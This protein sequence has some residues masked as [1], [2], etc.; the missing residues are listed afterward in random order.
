MNVS[1]P[2][3]DVQ[4]L[5]Q[6]M[7]N[8]LSDDQLAY[9]SIIDNIT[10]SLSKALMVAEQPGGL[11][12]D[13]FLAAI[14]EA[15]QSAMQSLTE[16]TFPLTLS[17]QH[18]ILGIVQDSLKLIVQPDMSFAS[19]RNISLLILMRAESIIQQTIPERFAEYPLSG[20]KVATTYLE[21]IAT[22][23]GPDNWNQIILTEMMTIQ[24]LLPANSTAHTYVSALINVTNFILESGQG[25]SLWA[26]FQNASVQNVN[27]IIGQMGK[28][29]S[30]LW[31]L[32]MGRPGSHTTAPPLEAFAHFAP[33]LEQVMTN[34]ADQDTWHKL[35]KMLEALLSTLKGTEL[36]ENV[37][38]V[39]P[40]FEKIVES[41][42]KN[43]QAEN[44]LIQSLQMPVVT[45]MK[46]IAQSVNTSHFN[47]SE[48]LG[49]SEWQHAIERLLQAAEQVR[50]GSLLCTLC[51]TVF[52][53]LHSHLLT[54]FL[55]TRLRV[56]VC[57]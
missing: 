15:V 47:L 51:I 24:R 10:Q 49:S 38:S 25:M 6:T 52:H 40:A 11:Q 57:V 46:E 12:S 35:E 14:L 5:L 2:V 4:H 53:C 1:T 48:V 8:I 33:V 26:S 36:W 56:C 9:L 37:Q 7:G 50:L 31:P 34:Q 18:N 55:W 17:V 39:I 41:A 19:S 42:V 29:V 27:G 23:S 16:A 45:L 54:P 44:V 32:I 13:L 20:L 21:S 28:L 3:M 43:T 30:M 22:A